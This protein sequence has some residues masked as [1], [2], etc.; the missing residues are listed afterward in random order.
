MSAAAA[1]T[2]PNTPAKTTKAS[3]YVSLKKTVL[4]PQ[5]DVAGVVSIGDVNAHLADTQR[6]LGEGDDD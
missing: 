6:L 2:T 4:D 3:V 1:N 5:G